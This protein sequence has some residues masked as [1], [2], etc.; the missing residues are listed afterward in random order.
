V[1]GEVLDVDVFG[2]GLGKCRHRDRGRGDGG[3]R[4]E[5]EHSR[6]RLV[7]VQRPQR[8]APVVEH[9]EQRGVAEVV[10]PRHVE[11][12]AVDLGNDVA[13][14][15][16][17]GPCEPADPPRRLQLPSAGTGIDLAQD[18]VPRR[19]GTERLEV[20]NGPAVD[21][22]RDRRAAECPGRHR[23]REPER[24]LQALPH[25]RQP[26][27]GFQRAERVRERLGQRSGAEDR[28][29][30]LAGHGGD[31]AALQ[32]PHATVVIDG[33]F[34]V[35]RPAER[36]RRPLGQTCQRAQSPRGDARRSAGGLRLDH[37]PPFGGQGR[38]PTGVEAAHQTVRPALA[39]REQQPIGASADGIGAEQHAAPARRELG[40]H[41]NR[42]GGP[43]D[44]LGTGRGEDVV[45]GP[46][47]RRRV[48]HVQ[49]RREDPGH[50]G[51][52]PVLVGGRGAD[53]H[54]ATTLV[55]HPTPRAPRRAVAG[56]RAGRMR[57]AAVIPRGREHHAGQHRQ[58]SPL[59]KRQ[60]GRL[61]AGERGITGVCV[62]EVDQAG[63]R[64]RRV[65]GGSVRARPRLQPVGRM[66]SAGVPGR[67]APG[68]ADSSC[69]GPG[70]GRSSRWC[71]FRGSWP[72]P[73]VPS[74]QRDTG[75][76]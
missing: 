29:R 75:R 4:L 44:E 76:P 42:H 28:A 2:P 6:Q 59:G 15:R 25:G 63:P 72:D 33:P 36:G 51:R 38:R 58:P 43:G 14:D 48:G 12:V 41:Q 56:V 9:R 68:A 31:R 61:R 62:G 26:Q 60:I 16:G 46:H 19:H 20:G 8:G 11:E 18:A 22:A 47:E 24:V 3:R 74:W 67:E 54:G 23:A 52:A 40:L 71:W 69:S 13:T 1:A 55:G 37:H 21:L 7:A 34:D 64:R 50:G 39:G 35:L 57:P 70:H 32:Q 10:E 45:D 65:D 27:V 49:H 17:Q 73:V 30:R 53:D 5:H 66:Q